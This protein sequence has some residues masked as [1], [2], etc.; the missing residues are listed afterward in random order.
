MDNEEWVVERCKFNENNVLW[1]PDG[2][3]CV[4][5]NEALLQWIRAMANQTRK[6]RYTITYTLKS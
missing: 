1:I 6:Y 2:I 3:I 5:D 4:S